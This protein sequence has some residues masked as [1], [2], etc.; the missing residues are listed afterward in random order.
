MRGGGG[1][2]AEREDMCVWANSI[3]P[4]KPQIFKGKKGESPARPSFHFSTK[5]YTFMVNVTRRCIGTVGNVSAEEREG[6]KRRNT[7]VRMYILARI[8]EEGMDRLNS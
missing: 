3:C 7:H 5:I 2:E 1:R 6:L 8:T 4:P